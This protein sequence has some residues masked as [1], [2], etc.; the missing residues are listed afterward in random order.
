VPDFLSSP[1]SLLVL[2]VTVLIV[3][4]IALFMLWRARRRAFASPLERATFS[5]LHTVSLAAPALRE[6]LSRQSAAFALPYLRTLLETCALTMTDAQAQSLAWDGEADHH[7]MD[8][9]E[10]AKQVVETGRQQ[11]ASHTAIDCGRDDCVVKGIV[12]S[13][14]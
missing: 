10:L 5:T 9:V 12:V 8:V 1:S 14:L 3:A 2:L 13:A 11:V 6:G 4:T 7:T